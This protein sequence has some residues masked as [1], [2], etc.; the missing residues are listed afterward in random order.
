MATNKYHNN[1]TE[2]DFIFIKENY[3]KMLI[4][5]MAKELNKCPATISKALKKLGLKKYSGWTKEEL[6]FLKDNYLKMTYTEMSKILNK[7]SSTIENKAKSLNL[8][9][10]PNNR[11]WTE[12]ELNFLKNNV[13]SKTYSE[14]AKNINRPLTSIRYK[15]YDLNLIPDYAKKYKFLKKEQID[16]I[17]ANYDKMT[18]MDLA[19]KFGVSESAIVSVRK[20]HGNK[21]SGNDVSGPTYI[22]KFV[23]SELD[24]YNIKYKFNKP[25]GKY[26]PDI[27]IE[28]TKIIIEIQGDYF[29]CNP[30]VYENGPKDEI[31][32]KHVLRDYYKK[33]YFLYNK[34]EIIEIWEYDI[35][36]YPE[37]T[38]NKLRKIASA[39]LSQ[40]S[41][42]T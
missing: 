29:H 11:N 39:V 42:K 17:L 23:M 24:K 28:N 16:F 40:S 38:K 26:R 14:L 2:N 22:E 30:M 8:M 19:K 37:E 5:D 10:N 31:Q 7:P 27:Q 36:H 41:L 9:K 15:V 18:D 34:Y 32:I 33:C 20:K 35:I 3:Q 13:G 12:E 6:E 1:M 21:K 25:L 4:K